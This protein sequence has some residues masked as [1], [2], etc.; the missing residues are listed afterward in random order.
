MT[1]ARLLR[2]AVFV[3]EFDYTNKFKNGEANSNVDCLSRA[4]ITQ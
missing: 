1:L 3:S 4:L 2:Y